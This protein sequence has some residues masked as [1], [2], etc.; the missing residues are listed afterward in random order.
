MI[1]D[2]RI[3]PL[4]GR[5]GPPAAVSQWLGRS[6]G[7]WEGDTL[8]I[9]TTNL[10]EPQRRVVERLTRMGADAIDYRVTVVRCGGAA[11]PARGS[12]GSSQGT[13]ALWPP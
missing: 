9:E 6:S 4:D 2:A 5:A 7:R 10:Q 1:H 3:V 11:G 12:E 8:V 13:V